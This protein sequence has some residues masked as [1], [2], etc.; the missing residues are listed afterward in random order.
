MPNWLKILSKHSFC[1][2]H[3]L[4]CILPL[5]FLLLIYSLLDRKE[6]LSN[7]QELLE[8]QIIFLLA[9]P[10]Q[11]VY[12][13]NH[14]LF[15]TT[16][17]C[18]QLERALLVSPL[19]EFCFCDATFNTFAEMHQSSIFG[20]FISR[21]KYTPLE[22]NYQVVWAIVTEAS[23]GTKLQNITR[24]VD[25][26]FIQSNAISDSVVSGDNS[27][28]LY[29]FS[30]DNLP[31]RYPFHIEPKRSLF[32]NICSNMIRKIHIHLTD[33]QDRPIDLNNI[34]VSLI[35]ILKGK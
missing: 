27:D 6:H 26:V 16:F 30:V 33:T 8:H 1:T 25:N 20:F 31:L 28:I 15:D 11:E 3:T 34:P 14:L 29:R 19:N 12:Q 23:Y 2:V 32:S 17:N 10:L 35:L 24:S 4:L 9:W 18:P 22:R 21:Y 7:T 13:W 5:F